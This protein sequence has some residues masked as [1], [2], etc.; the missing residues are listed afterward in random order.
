[1]TELVV[2]SREEWRDYWLKCYKNRNPDADVGPGSYPWVRA[3]TLAE[4]LTIL[5]AD[6][7]AVSDSIPLDNM[8]GS[9][10]DAK[11][12]SKLPRN[13]ES[14]ASG[15]I[16]ISTSSAGSTIYI[17]DLLTHPS[18]RNQYE[19]TSV[20]AT[21]LNG[22]QLAVRSV[23]PG[24]GQNITPGEVLQWVSPRPGCYAT[25]VVFSA[26]DGQGIV[27]GRATES[28]DEYR[29]RIRDFNASPIGHGNEGD[30][31]ALIEAT[32]EHGVPVEKGFVYPAILGDGTLAYGFTVRRDNYW[33]SRLPSSLQITDV[34]DY[35]SGKLPG[36]FAITPAAIAET[37]TVIDLSLSLD[38]RYSQWADFS[39]WPSYTARTGGMKVIGTATSPSVFTIETDDADYT[40]E[41]APVPGN[42]IA[43]YD[44]AFGVFRRK[45]IL[46]V[47]G[48]GPWSITC[49]TTTNQTDGT[50]TPVAGQAISP[51]FD[52]INDCAAQAGKFVA[53]MGPSEIVAVGDMPADGTRMARQ[54]KPYPGQWN[55][56]VT[57]DIAYQVKTNVAPVAT[58]SL[59]AATPSTPPLGT[60]SVL[61]I[62]KTSDL[63]I[64]KA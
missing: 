25:A 6:A 59:L 33:E 13:L 26:T 34:F 11:Y 1:M 47:L 32:R 64:F 31:L 49:D 51:W 9:Q 38:P 36:D 52:A 57:S 28:D 15:Y 18:T 61:Q 62:L 42:T 21:Y 41:V 24:L 16:T 35:V 5:S 44:A 58:C 12:G 27:G 14:K 63:A 22:V 23:D 56:E 50:Y 46:T 8:T 10:L 48:A 17:G 30:V 40:G 39:P 19:V 55:D 7:L 43:V 53:A 4:A 54:P 45:K 2:K 29:E 3:S 37:N 20:T 60:V